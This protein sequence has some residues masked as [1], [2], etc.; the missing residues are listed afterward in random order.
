MAKLGV[1]IVSSAISG[2][3]LTLSDTAFEQS[4]K[5]SD[6]VQELKGQVAA[7]LALV[8]AGQ[9]AQAPVE[10]PVAKKVA[11]PKGE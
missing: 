10:A 5:N 4:K 2:V 6:E 1:T 9:A 7:L 11:A 8:A 3:P